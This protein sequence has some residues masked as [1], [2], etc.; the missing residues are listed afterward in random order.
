M[1]SF[2]DFYNEIYTKQ[3]LDAAI[4]AVIKLYNIAPTTESIPPHERIRNAFAITNKQELQQ[5]GSAKP[6]PTAAEQPSNY[7]E[8]VRSRCVPYWYFMQGMNRV[9]AL[10]TKYIPMYNL[11][12][13]P[14]LSKFCSEVIQRALPGAPGQKIS[15]IASECKQ[16]ASDELAVMEV[17]SDTVLSASIATPDK[18]ALLEAIAMR[19]LF[20]GYFP[21]LREN[22]E[23]GDTQL[24]VVLDRETDQLL[25]DIQ[26]TVTTVTDMFGV[27]PHGKLFLKE[28][29]P[30]DMG[31]GFETLTVSDH[32][33]YAISVMRQYQLLKGI[34]KY[35][36]MIGIALIY[37]GNK[38]DAWVTYL[39]NLLIQLRLCSG[40]RIAVRELPKTEGIDP[41]DVGKR[42]VYAKAPATI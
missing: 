38:T 36:Y 39:C 35:Y 10:E 15:E 21:E 29:K 34:D 32:T 40:S 22:P 17:L 28:T 11:V 9:F 12:N 3:G 5:S 1:K 2:D 18:E 23:T 6:T 13:I 41:L 30:F 26:D 20:F 27:A 37:S 14:P 42:F 7:Y 33:E 16:K 31:D 24:T 4:D 8:F 25:C 19:M